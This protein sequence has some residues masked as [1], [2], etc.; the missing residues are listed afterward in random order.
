MV[1]KRKSHITHFFHRLV[2]PLALWESIIS[3][4]KG[5]LL[6]K[7]GSAHRPSQHQIMEIIIHIQWSAQGHPKCK[8]F[9]SSPPHSTPTN[10]RFHIHLPPIQPIWNSPAVYACK[11]PCQIF[12]I[13]KCKAISYINIFYFRK[14]SINWTPSLDSSTWAT[15]LWFQMSFSL[16]RDNQ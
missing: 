4:S 12:H 2:S 7:I 16:V 6:T 1:C 13:V 9:T 15:H 8:Q 11:K 3:K 10:N 14:M 5:K